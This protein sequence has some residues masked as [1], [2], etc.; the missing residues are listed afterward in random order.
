MKTYRLHTVFE[1]SRETIR[2]PSGRRVLGRP[3]GVLTSMRRRKPLVFQRFPTSPKQIQGAAGKGSSANWFT[4]EGLIA[5]TYRL[6]N[7]FEGSW[8][9]L[10]RNS[11]FWPAHPGRGT[12]KCY[13]SQW[14]CNVSG[15]QRGDIF[16]GRFRA[17]NPL[18]PCPGHVIYLYRCVCVCVETTKGHSRYQ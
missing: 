10:R 7:V 2:S 16:L 5:K 14:F 15:P 17:D 13:V 11:C 4:Q 6:R 1:G 12:P 8:G 3:Q 9:T 18:N